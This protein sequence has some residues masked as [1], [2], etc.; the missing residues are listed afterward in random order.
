MPRKFI[1]GS[2]NR[3]SIRREIYHPAIFRRSFLDRSISVARPLLIGAPFSS[4]ASSIARSIAAR[5]PA[6]SCS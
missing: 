5:A 3:I 4:R 1:T 6:V 2:S